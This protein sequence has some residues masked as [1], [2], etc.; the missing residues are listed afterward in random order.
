MNIK[1]QHHVINTQRDKA[2]GVLQRDC[3][4][5]QLIKLDETQITQLGLSFVQS[6]GVI[7]CFHLYRQ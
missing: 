4:H 3:S 6:R 1:D 5:R 7:V 2:S